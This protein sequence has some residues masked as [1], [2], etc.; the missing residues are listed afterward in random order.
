MKLLVDREWHLAKNRKDPRNLDQISNHIRSIKRLRLEDF[1][2]ISRS[3]LEETKIWLLRSITYINIPPR[4]VFCEYKQILS[5]QLIIF[6]W[7]GT[8]E[9]VFWHEKK[10]G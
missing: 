2:I 10:V 7:I 9:L 1:F 3:H 4:L 5:R 6:S 8:L